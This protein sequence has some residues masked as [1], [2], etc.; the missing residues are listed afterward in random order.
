M[1]EGGAGA[2]YGGGDVSEDDWLPTFRDRAACWV[3][4]PASDE[5]KGRSAAGPGSTSLVPAALRTWCSWKPVTARTG[6][7][8]LCRCALLPPGS[9]SLL[10]LAWDLRGLAVH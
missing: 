10:E 3:Q 5:L 4:S 7:H 1:A 8:G 2:P 9:N 6:L